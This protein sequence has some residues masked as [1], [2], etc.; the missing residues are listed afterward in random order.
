MLQNQTFHLNS[1]LRLSALR[2]LGKWFAI[3]ADSAPAAAELRG[4]AG[5][6]VVAGAPWLP[7]WATAALTESHGLDSQVQASLP[8]NKQCF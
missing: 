5:R 6:G 3:G 7:A 8:L 4:E 1:L 2:V